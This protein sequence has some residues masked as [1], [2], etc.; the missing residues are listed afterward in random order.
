MYS[1]AE[2]VEI[3]TAF[4]A[5][6]E[7]LVGD[8]LAVSRVQE[9]R[10]GT[11]LYSEGDACTAI[12]LLLS[13]EI[14]V[15][16]VGE[17]GREITLYEFGRGETCILNAS[18]IMSQIPYPAE[19]GVT[20]QGQMLLLP[21]H[22]FRRLIGAYEEMR[23][24]FCTQLSQRL[25]TMM[26]L[27]EEVAFRKMDDRL[28]DYITEKSENGKLHVTHQRIAADLGTSRE[29]VSRLLKDFERKG[30][31]SLSRNL[32]SLTGF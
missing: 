1:I 24:F 12:A 3:F 30:R 13:G 29:V 11:H 26:A 17:T 32:I 2:F 14:R 6:P 19:A 15:Y 31:V 21:A 16:K 4:R 9:V 5:A 7:S 8:I 25:T 27:I 18:C 20:A 22:D 10:K 23:E 28:L